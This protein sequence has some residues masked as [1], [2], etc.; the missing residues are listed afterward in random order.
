MPGEREKEKKDSV[1]K[2]SR[3]KGISKFL[4]FSEKITYW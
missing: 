1:K 2:K 3:K 4:A